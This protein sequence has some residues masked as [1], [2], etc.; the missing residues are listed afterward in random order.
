MVPVGVASPVH[1]VDVLAAGVAVDIV[2]VV[3]DSGLVFVPAQPPISRQVSNKHR[4]PAKKDVY[5]ATVAE[6]DSR[7]I[8]P[9]RMT[10]MVAI[11]RR[12]GSLCNRRTFACT[13]VAVFFQTAR[14]G[15][16]AGHDGKT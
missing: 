12:R 10:T 7:W 8:I 13:A 15:H 1:I 11:R 3:A 6:P 9:H 4:G 14:H 2:V 5:V 16:D